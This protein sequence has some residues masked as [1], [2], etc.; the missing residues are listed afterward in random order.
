[1]PKFRIELE[2]DYDGVLGLEPKK[3]PRSKSHENVLMRNAVYAQVEDAMTQYGLK[4]DVYL[5]RKVNK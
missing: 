1:M 4:G 3:R 5:V 2:L